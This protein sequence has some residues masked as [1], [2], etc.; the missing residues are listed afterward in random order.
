MPS[1]S[2][3]S[4]TT[5]AEKTMAYIARVSN[6]A[7]QTNENYAKLLK[8]CIDHG[9][10]SVFEH[11]FM[12][13][14]IETSLAVATQILRHR[15][16]TFQQFSQRYAR[17]SDD[18]PA[19]QLRAKHP[20]N[21]QLSLDDGLDP[22]VVDAMRQEIDAHFRRGKALYDA[23]LEKGVAGECA[24][25]VLPQATPTKIYM[26][27]NCRNWIHYIRVREG[28]GSQPEHVEIAKLVKAVF[29]AQFPVVAA[30]LGW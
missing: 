22:C 20:T 21:R 8:Y 14:E 19:P 6:P 10:W 30:A 17:V 15:S 16:F 9:H 7:N 13:V 23:L 4:R 29:C 28:D 27:G 2:L 3:V 18:I 11:A 26:T 5:D 12:T 25:F 24:R 1:V